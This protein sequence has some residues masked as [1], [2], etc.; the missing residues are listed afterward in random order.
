[1]RVMSLT[2]S[3]DSGSDAP[4]RARFSV[5]DTAIS[6]PLGAAL[7]GMIAAFS[8][9]VGWLQTLGGDRIFHLRQRTFFNARVRP[10]ACRGRSP[11]S[12]P[13]LL[14]CLGVGLPHCLCLSRVLPR[15]QPHAH[16]DRTFSPGFSLNSMVE[17]YDIVRRC[18]GDNVAKARIPHLKRVRLALDQLGF[19]IV[20]P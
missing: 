13:L 17:V 1:M 7:L 9:L 3:S 11:E 16:N 5:K 20:P 2:S 14:L 4:L 15:R 18:A 6:M 8:V 10:S 12:F 19:E